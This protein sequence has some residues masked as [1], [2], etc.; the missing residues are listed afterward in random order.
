[1]AEATNRAAPA[2]NIVR[3]V[4]RESI[5]D[6]TFMVAAGVAFFGLFS[7]LP[8]LAVMG[9]VL[10][11]LIEPGAIEGQVTQ[12]ADILPEGIPALMREFLIA[13]PGSLAAGLGL[14]INLLVVFWTVQR[15][16]SGLITALNVVYDESEG[17]G[18]LHREAVAISIAVSGL[19]FLYTALI[20]AI[21]VPALD[22]A[23][24]ALQWLSRLRWPILTMFFLAGSVLLYAYAPCKRARHWK[25]IAWGAGVGTVLWVLASLLFIFYMNSVGG[26]DVYYGSVTAA[27]VLMSWLFITAFIVMVG[28]E[29][30]AQIVALAHPEPERGVKKILDRREGA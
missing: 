10:A 21:V 11:W 29:V 23:A 27:V 20:L 28:A 5:T 22:P 18:R 9:L 14:S 15:A 3:C 30:D 1:M 13:V 19:V 2:L 12:A 8:A 7:L 25:G 16:A 4:W 26:W 6:R 24:T 17:R